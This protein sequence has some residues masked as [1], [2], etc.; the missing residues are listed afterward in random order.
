MKKFLIVRK[1]FSFAAALQTPVG[2]TSGL[3]SE[4]RSFRR[5]FHLLPWVSLIQIDFTDR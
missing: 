4:A 3:R 5:S 1:L 2:A